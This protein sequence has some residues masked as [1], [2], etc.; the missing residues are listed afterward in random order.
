MRVGQAL[1]NCAGFALFGDFALPQKA[2]T[3]CGEEAVLHPF[4]LSLF[5]RVKSC[6]FLSAWLLGMP[7]S[8][9]T[10]SEAL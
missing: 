4:F 10:S 6:M 2:G 9:E 3:G 7:S 8:T 5:D 1:Q